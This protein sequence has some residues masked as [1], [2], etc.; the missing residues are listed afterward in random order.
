MAQTTKNTI[1]W[2]KANLG[3]DVMHSKNYA[4][5]INHLNEVARIHQYNDKVNKRNRDKMG[6]PET[7]SRPS[8]LSTQQMKTREIKVPN[9]IFQKEDGEVGPI[10]HE[11]LAPLIRKNYGKL[12]P[13]FIEAAAAGL[14]YDTEGLKQF[15]INLD[16]AM[17]H[18][19]EMEKLKKPAAG[20][21]DPKNDDPLKWVVSLINTQLD[22]VRQGAGIGPQLQRELT[23]AELARYNV[24]YDALLQSTIESIRNDKAINPDNKKLMID[25][26]ERSSPAQIATDY[27][28]NTQDIFRGVQA[29]EI[30]QA[31][32]LKTLSKMGY[33]HSDYSEFFST[34][35]T[36]RK[37]LSAL[38]RQ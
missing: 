16:N 30:T 13:S 35:Y 31:E 10:P 36:H 19:R 26:I 9:I 14:T 22:N 1:N 34:F 20:G 38:E 37:Y 2:L 15:W 32:A 24:G 17:T 12:D 27:V 3:K 18:M 29:K 4:D 28:L 8:V 6:Q 7:V 25:Y 11:E 23:A 33:Q 5:T 21:A